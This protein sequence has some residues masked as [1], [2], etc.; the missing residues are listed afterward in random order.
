MK[1]HESIHLFKLDRHWSIC[2]CKWQK[3]SI[4][5][6]SVRQGL[7]HHCFD[8][9][10]LMMPSE[11]ERI[12]VEPPSPKL[13][14]LGGRALLLSSCISAKVCFTAM[15]MTARCMGQHGANLGP[16]GPRW[17]PCWP[18]EPCYLGEYSIHLNMFGMIIETHRGSDY[19]VTW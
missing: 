4:C 7:G 2:R 16:T 12:V 14:C 10:V 5:R 18:H 8:V 17:A 1:I 9:L 6:A 19:P 15:T 11:V 13:Y 3:I